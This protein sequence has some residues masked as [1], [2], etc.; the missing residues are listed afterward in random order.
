MQSM[1]LGSASE[2]TKQ[3]NA[4]LNCSPQGP[5]AIPPRQ[6]HPQLISPVSGLKAP[7]WPASSS[8]AS[9]D[10]SIEAAGVAA[11]DGDCCSEARGSTFSLTTFLLSS[12]SWICFLFSST[13]EST[14]GR[15]DS[16][17]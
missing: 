6:G 11:E 14:V 2:Y 17:K 8:S 5:S 7:C 10:P 16:E 9:G 1:P 15:S 3:L 13:M 12:L 4:A